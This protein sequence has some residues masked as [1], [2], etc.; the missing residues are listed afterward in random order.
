[1]IHWGW[2]LLAFLLGAT[3]GAGVAAWY[4]G[5]ASLRLVVRIFEQV[6]INDEAIWG[7][8]RFYGRKPP[9]GP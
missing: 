7:A 5:H 6:E 1:M 4:V 2:L 9:G 3:I 8:A